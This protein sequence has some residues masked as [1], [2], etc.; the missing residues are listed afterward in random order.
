[1]RRTTVALALLAVLTTSAASAGE[2]EL[3]FNDENF[4]AWLLFGLGDDDDAQFLIGGRYL[5]SA[6]DADDASVPAF[7]VAYSSRPAANDDMRFYVGV[8]GLV[9]EA[10]EQDIHGLAVGGSLTW[11]PETW[12]GVFVGG[13]LFYAPEVFCFDDTEGIFEWAGQGGYEINE[14]VRVFLQYSGLTSDLDGGGEAE[15]DVGLT[16][17]VNL[18][19]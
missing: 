13:R 2:V 3:T 6:S 5:Y 12:K 9:G 16:V 18:R 14:R 11:A 10:S 17:G 8:Q 1:M 4:D 19:F 7:L 15:V